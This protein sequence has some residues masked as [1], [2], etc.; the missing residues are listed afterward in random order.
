MAAYMKMCYFCTIIWTIIAVKIAL[1]LTIRSMRHIV[2]IVTL[3]SRDSYS[4]NIKIGF[5]CS[6]LKSADIRSYITITFECLYN[7]MINK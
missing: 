1:K 7:V 4:G 6:G 5:M 2:H 3:R